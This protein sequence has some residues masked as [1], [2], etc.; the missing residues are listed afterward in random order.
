MS[1]EADVAARFARA[2]TSLTV[3]AVTGTNGKTT[4]TTMIETIIRASGEPHA[5]LTTLGC[6]LEGERIEAETEAEEFLTT[7]E[8]AVDRRVRT[9]ALEVTSKALA[10][11]F[12]ARFPPHVAVFTNLSRDHLEAHGSPEAYLAA[13]AQL[14]LALGPGGVAVLNAD[15]PASELLAEL[16]RRDVPKR[17]FS[18]SIDADLRATRIDARLDGTTVTLGPSPLA[19]RLGGS[20]ELRALGAVHA[21]NAMAAALACDALGYGADAIRRGLAEFPG[22]PGRFEVVSRTPTVVVDYAHTPDGL[23]GTLRTARG[24]VGKGGKLLVVFGCGGARDRGKR[25]EMGA[26]AS[27]LA[28]EV[29]VTTDNPRNE[30]PRTIADAI[31]EGV[32]PGARVRVELDRERAITSAVRA[33]RE[34]DLVVIAGKGHETTQELADR[35]IPFS[36]ADVVRRVLG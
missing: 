2:H 33:A 3:A 20:L 21:E 26:I 17:T 28:D 6:Y 34:G 22:V 12:A 5:R 1:S 13:K 30:D 14:F 19:S 31:L 25:A 9:L 15:D 27:R 4:T 11:G 7:I 32:V 18:K 35:T 8:R 23:D 16:I 10:F 36:D 24:L 29:V